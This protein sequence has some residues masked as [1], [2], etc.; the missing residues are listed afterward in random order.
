MKESILGW[1]QLLTLLQIFKTIRKCTKYLAYRDKRYYLE[2]K[3]WK[4]SYIWFL[5]SY[6]NQ[7]LKIV[8]Q[9]MEM[10][11]KELRWKV[12]QVK[13]LK[14]MI[15]FLNYRIVFLP[16]HKLSS[17]TLFSSPIL[18]RFNSCV[19]NNFC[20]SKSCFRKEERNFCAQCCARTLV[21]TAQAQS[22]GHTFSKHPANCCTERICPGRK[23][24]KH[25]VNVFV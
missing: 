20:K 12:M 7:T 24:V 15:Y 13:N 22:Y 5:H 3:T 25:F 19:G 2:K 16:F 10:T 1:N 6:D 17:T 23:F 21:F 9:D 11:A 8:I 4:K 18:P 14:F